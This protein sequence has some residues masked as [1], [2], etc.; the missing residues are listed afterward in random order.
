MYK[1]YLVENYSIIN[2]TNKMKKLSLFLV[3]ILSYFSSF[4]Q[5]LSN[6]F[7]VSVGEPYQV[8]DAG[9]KEYISLD[10]GYALMVKMGRGVV[11]IQK[12]DINGMKEVA[13]NTYDDL[14]KG[15]IFQNVLKLN[16]NVYYFY[17]I[18]N[19]KEKNFTLYSR[20]IDTE[21]TSFKQ[22]VEIIKTS[23][24]VTPVEATGEL[25]DAKVGLAGMVRDIK[26][27]FHKSFDESKLLITYRLYPKSKNDAENYDEIGFFVFDNKISKQWGSEVK[28]PYTEKQINNVAY[29]V[30]KNGEAKMLVANRD[31][32]VYE[33]I[34]VLPSGETKVSDLGISTDQLVKTLKVNETANGNFIYAGFYA[35]GIEFTFNPFTGGNFKFNANGLMLF[36]IDNDGKLVKNKNYEFTKEFIQQNLNERLKKQVE[37]REKDG[38]AG[39]FDLYLLDFVV[40]DDNSCVFIGERQWLV[41]EYW[42]TQK[43]AV[44][45]FG[46]AVAIKVDANGEL[47]WMKKLPKNQAGVMGSGQMGI[48]YM[49]GKENDYVAFVDN[50]KNIELDAS[51]GIPVAHKDGHGGYL[52]TYKINLATGNMEK[53]SICNLDQIESYKAYQFKPTRI[54]KVSPNEFLMEIYIKDKKD[55][56]VKFKVN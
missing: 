55:T 32:K 5:E 19:K 28:L 37:E 46:N 11:N 50:I 22:A 52:T 42:G 7:K 8:I 53:H 17:L 15:A 43:K 45:H 40:K 39:I 4:T 48:S 27:D 9:S 23:R 16:D 35:N 2:Q 41:N 10:N 18:Y 14:P 36:E 51:G 3:L 33:A 49:E 54:L 29:A 12:Y 6:D 26:F 13:R 38:K 24:K 34:T 56:M 1:L 20:E 44:Y 31:K 25:T 30:G 47:A 21:A